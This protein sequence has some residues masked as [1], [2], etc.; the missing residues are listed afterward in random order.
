MLWEM[1]HYA[2]LENDNG[3]LKC[4]VGEL[5]CWEEVRLMQRIH[6]HLFDGYT[7]LLEDVGQIRIVLLVTE[8]GFVWVTCLE[9]INHIVG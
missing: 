8:Y 4:L 7:L 9:H 2:I 5:S 1:M 3:G 6:F